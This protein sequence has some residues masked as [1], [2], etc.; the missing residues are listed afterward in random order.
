LPNNCLFRTQ[1]REKKREKELKA[2][3]ENTQKEWLARKKMAELEQLENIRLSLPKIKLI[4]SP[5]SACLDGNVEHAFQ[6]PTSQTQVRLLSIA[7][8]AVA[9]QQYN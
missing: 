6:M 2:Q 7:F 5:W 1:L 8:Q 3:E 4:K 9:K